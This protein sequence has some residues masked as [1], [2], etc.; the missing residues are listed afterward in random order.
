MAEN[1]PG[2][3]L[4]DLLVASGQKG[5]DLI[6]AMII[7]AGMAQA[8]GIPGNHSPEANETDLAAHKGG[9]M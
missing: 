7:A 1:D 3:R 5:I 6:L 2:F 4:G 8:A 9:A